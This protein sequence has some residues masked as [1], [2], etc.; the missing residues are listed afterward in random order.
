[1][2]PVPGVRCF[3]RCRTTRLCEWARRAKPQCCCPSDSPVGA[4]VS[5]PTWRT[6]WN[7]FHSSTRNQAYASGS[8]GAITIPKTIARR[9]AARQPQ[10]IFFR[11]R[12]ASRTRSL[13]DGVVPRGFV[14]AERLMAEIW[15]DPIGS[16]EPS[17]CPPFSC[18]ALRKTGEL[19]DVV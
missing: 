15:A 5:M 13:P 1:M 7:R 16:R 4:R 18:Q 2:V 19:P 14:V 8:C 10:P 17:S 3:Q 11:R 12:T 6:S 9:E